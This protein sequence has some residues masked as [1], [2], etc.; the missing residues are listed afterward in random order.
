[1]S[2][3]PAPTHSF[4]TDPIPQQLTELRIALD[5]AVETLART[6]AVLGC[7]ENR[8]RAV[9]HNTVGTARPDV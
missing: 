5:T 3:T 1:V 6:L 7:P 9:R 2:A 4:S 8:P